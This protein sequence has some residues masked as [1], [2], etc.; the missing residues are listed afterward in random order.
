MT[1]VTESAG[2]GQAVQ[3]EDAYAEYLANMCE[4][5]AKL[6]KKN[7]FDLGAYLLGMAAV[8]FVN[9]RYGPSEG[10]VLKC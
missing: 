3:N 8:E 1:N 6:A 4:Q 10:D 2:W 5:L 7:G 9:K